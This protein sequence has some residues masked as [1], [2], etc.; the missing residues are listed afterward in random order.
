[1]I[2]GLNLIK[3]GKKLWT[4]YYKLEQINTDGSATMY[5]PFEVTTTVRIRPALRAPEPVVAPAPAT[6][7][8]TAP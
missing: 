5:G 8:R 2:N 7:S 3:S 6:M 4:Y 1:M